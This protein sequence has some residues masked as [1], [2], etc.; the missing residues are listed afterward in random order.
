MLPADSRTEL[1]SEKLLR[2][3]QKAIA[4]KMQIPITL[5]VREAQITL[6]KVTGPKLRSRPMRYGAN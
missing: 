4:S 6:D 3:S 2:K 1:V 5:R